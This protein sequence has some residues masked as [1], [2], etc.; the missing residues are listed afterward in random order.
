MYT[1]VKGKKYLHLGIGNTKYKVSVDK[2]QEE[3]IYLKN[4]DL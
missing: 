2:Y 1:K 3:L 4:G